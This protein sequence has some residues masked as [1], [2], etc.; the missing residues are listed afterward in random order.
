MLNK[1]WY[2]INTGDDRSFFFQLSTVTPFTTPQVQD[3][4]ALDVGQDGFES[5]SLDAPWQI[6]T[7]NNGRVR[8]SDL[9]PYDGNY[10]ALLDASISGP[11]STAAIVLPYDLS[12]HTQVNLDFW[13]REFNDKNDIADGVFIMWHIFSQ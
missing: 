10:S 2:W 7:D 11:Y 13:W 6:D 3:C 1:L 12:S 5:G 4:L 8:I 9:Y